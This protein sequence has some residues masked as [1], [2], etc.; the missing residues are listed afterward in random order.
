MTAEI[1]ARAGEIVTN[2]THEPY[3]EKAMAYLEPVMQVVS[4]PLR[5]LS[6]LSDSALNAGLDFIEQNAKLALLASHAADFSQRLG[7]INLNGLLPDKA[8]W[9]ALGG[10]LLGTLAAATSKPAAF[11][12]WVPACTLLGAVGDFAQILSK[13][14]S[15]MDLTIGGAVLGIVG[16]GITNARQNPGI[17]KTAT[18]IAAGLGFVF[19]DVIGDT[20]FGINIDIGR[21]L[22]A[23]AQIPSELGENLKHVPGLK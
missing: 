4:H 7:N 3:R 6:Q 15:Q 13:T 9:G 22:K 12:A 5:E 10:A 1:L 20:V 17:I 11:L 19:G 8:L 14:D 2:P 18:L 16:A 21:E 23:I